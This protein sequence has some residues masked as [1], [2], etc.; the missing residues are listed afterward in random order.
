MPLPDQIFLTDRNPR[1]VGAWEKAFRGV[2]SVTA[3]EGDY[4]AEPADAVV[5]PANSFGYMD[6]GLDL[7]LA[8]TFQG[9]QHRV[10]TMIQREYHGEMPVGCAEVV[11]TGH[12]RWPYLICA[13]TMRVPEN[14]GQTVHPY[15]AFRATLLAVA[16]FNRQPDGPKIRTLIAPGLGTGVGRVS[17]KRCAQHMRQ[18]FDSLLHPPQIPNFKAI[19]AGHVRL[20]SS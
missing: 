7:L 15:L 16:K 2:H 20:I 6:G 19:Q 5:S 18:A 11:A 3:V 9:I 13:P 8:R 10:Q 14:I 12:E 17:E 1:L 4:L